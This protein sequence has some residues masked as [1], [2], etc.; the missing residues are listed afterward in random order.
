MKKNIKLIPNNRYK[1]FFCTVDCDIIGRE[2]MFKIR[3][4]SLRK[5]YLS[6]SGARSLISILLE[7]D[8]FENKNIIELKDGNFSNSYIVKNSDSEF[9]SICPACNKK[10]ADDDNLIIKGVKRKIKIHNDCRIRFSNIIDD[11][12]K[13]NSSTIILNDL[14][15]LKESQKESRFYYF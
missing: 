1:G 2:P 3:N 11:K 7:E 8:Y 5:S 9:N 13:N 14:S 15:S 10:I 12:I 6:L 4:N